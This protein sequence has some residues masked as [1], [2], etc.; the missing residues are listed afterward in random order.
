MCFYFG[1]FSYFFF[2]LLYIGSG[3]KSGC[4]KYTDSMLQR[5]RIYEGEKKNDWG[6]LTASLFC[7]ALLSSEQYYCHEVHQQ[8]T[9]DH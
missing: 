8:I 3:G 4:R 5:W 7:D 6:S 9:N 1:S 2:L